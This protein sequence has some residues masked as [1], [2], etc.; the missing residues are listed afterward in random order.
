MSAPASVTAYFG[1]SV[2][3]NTSS[4][5]P[6]F[7]VDNT[8]YTTPQ[9]FT[10]IVGSSHTIATTST[11]AGGTGT[12]YV[13]NNWSDGGSLSHTVTAPSSA[14]TYI[15]NFTTQYQLTTTVSPAAAGDISPASG[16]HN[17]GTV[18]TIQANYSPGYG[19]SSWSSTGG[20]FAPNE[21]YPTY[22][23]TITMSVPSSVTANFSPAAFLAGSFG[24]PTGTLGGV[25][26]WPVMFTNTG[27]LAATDVQIYSVT[28]A[29]LPPIGSDVYPPCSSGTPVITSTFPLTVTSS[30]AVGA[31]SPAA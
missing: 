5:G 31:T 17:A 4:A 30:I 12:Q 28:L 6:S 19:F 22:E 23:A 9:T 14:I 24:T 21:E 16:W 3:V 27:N 7:T 29:I 26:T 15:A 8:T 10:W 18:V 25:R 2:T 13:F 20:A 11:Q 1:V